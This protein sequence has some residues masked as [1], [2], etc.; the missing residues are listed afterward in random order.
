MIAIKDQV[1]KT[2]TEV[3]LEVKELFEKA[4]HGVKEMFKSESYKEYLDFCSSFYNYSYNNVMLIKAQEP[5]ASKVASYKDWSSKY[6]RYPKK[7][8]SIKILAPSLSYYV[9]KNGVAIGR[10]SYTDQIKKD[11]AAGQITEYKKLKFVKAD[12]WDVRHTVGKELPSIITPLVNTE[13]AERLYT[14]ASEMIRKEFEIRIEAMDGAKGYYNL[15]EKFIA[16][17]KENNFTQNLKTLIHEYAHAKMHDP[18]NK[19]VVAGKEFDETEVINKVNTTL[20][21]VIAEEGLEL[22][23]KDMKVFSGKVQGLDLGTNRITVILQYSGTEKQDVIYGLLNKEDLVLDDTLIDVQ[24][25]ST[26][27]WK[28]IDAFI[29]SN[30]DH[31]RDRQEVEAESVAYIVSNYMGIDTSDYSFG[32]ITGWSKNE[33]LETLNLSGKAIKD[34]SKEIIEKFEQYKE[35]HLEKENEVTF[36]KKDCQER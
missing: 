27:R 6:E 33:S 13:N 14:M 3:D 31:Y 32:Y 8:E 2:K 1:K 7:G 10:R 12:V 25:I 28:S 4:R 30:K 26:D 22:S 5:S 23:V 18:D 20:E 36:E 15:K 9:L 29:S 24:V 35:K 19:I 34:A 17:N 11:L 16:L 21:K